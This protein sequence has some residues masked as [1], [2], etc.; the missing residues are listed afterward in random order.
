MVGRGESERQAAAAW[1]RRSESG[2]GAG[3]GARLLHSTN[4]KDTTTT[5]YKPY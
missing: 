2:G 5:E 3:I 4:V 1:K